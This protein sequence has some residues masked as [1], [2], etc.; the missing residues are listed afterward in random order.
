MTFLFFFTLL[1][2]NGK[3]T[4]THG[5]KTYKTIKKQVFWLKSTKKNITLSHHKKSI[6]RNAMAVSKSNNYQ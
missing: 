6:H 2:Y 5:K 1:W 3:K 4:E